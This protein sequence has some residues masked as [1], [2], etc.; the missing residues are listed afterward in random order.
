[1]PVLA[2]DV[3]VKA[4]SWQEAIRASC[5]LLL[6]AG[7][8]AERYV[9]R[10]VEIVTEQGPYIVVAPG[11]ALAHARPEDGA[12]M[13]GLAVAT[14]AE[15]VRFGHAD[16]D[17]VDVVFA[18]SSPDRE[19]HVTLLGLL[20]RAIAGGLDERIRTASDATAA[21]GTLEEVVTGV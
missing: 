21:R 10:C 4:A 2:A 18:F 15:P 12:R 5:Q 13:L 17:P 20:S 7:A 1:M 8:V 9:E 19:R 14:L 6:A 3:A 11:I 16:N